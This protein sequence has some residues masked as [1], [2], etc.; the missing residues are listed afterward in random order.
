MNKPIG[1]IGAGSFGITVASLLSENSQVLIVVRRQETMDAINKDRF[2]KTKINENVRAI[3]DLKELAESCDLIFPVVPSDQFRQLM[4]KLAPYL[5]PYHF[6]IHGTKGFDVKLDAES[7]TIRRDM[8]FTMSEVIRQE[9][10]VERI[11]CLSGPNLATEILAGQPAATLIASPYTEVIK[12]GQK[13]LKTKNFQVY[14]SHDLLGAE[15]AGALKNIIALGAGILGGKLMGKNLWALLITRGLAEIVHIGVAMGAEA[16]SFLG[17]AG[18]G[19]LVATCSSDTSRNY[20]FGAKL[21]SGLSVE[22]I[23]NSMEETAEG[24]RTLKPIM[25]LIEHYKI[26]APITYILFKV[27]YRKY[28]IDSALEYLMTYRYEVDVDY[29]K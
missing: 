9:T 28:P 10:V 2:Y 16:K 6:L 23:A 27:F 15:L 14:G 1:V 26:H 17:V 11:G 5:R 12:A 7:Q 3:T 13:A 19:D 24:Y 29:I 21:A 20:T 25:A 18:I 4:Q 22:E 8:I